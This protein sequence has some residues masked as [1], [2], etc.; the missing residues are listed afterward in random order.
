MTNTSIT[1]S[2]AF[3]FAEEG[4]YTDDPLDPGGAT[5]LG[6]TLDELSRWRHTAVSKR[7]S[8]NDSG[9]GVGWPR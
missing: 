7:L 6:I 5:N 4:G 1:P 9:T 2:L 8:L 3:V